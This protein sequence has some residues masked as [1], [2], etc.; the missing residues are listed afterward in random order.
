MNSEYKSLSDSFYGDN[1]RWFIGTVVNNQDP[2]Q[3]GRVQVRIV[4]IHSNSVTQIPQ[5]ALPWAQVMMPGTEGGIS[6]IGQSI[7]GL[8]PGAQVFGI[9]IDGNQSQIPFIFGSIPKE[10]YPSVIQRGPN[11]I[12]GSNSDVYENNDTSGGTTDQSSVSSGRGSV[13]LSGNSNAEKGFNFFVASGR[14]T[15][16]QAAGL[17]GNF[18]QESNMDPTA[19][20]SFSGEGSTGIAQWNPAARAGARLQALKRF[21]SSIGANYLSLDAQLQFVIHELDTTEI[22]GGRSLLAAN[23]VEQA[24]EAICWNY[25]RPSREHANLAGRIRYAQS[26]YKEFG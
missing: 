22:S 26:A 11:S 15:P 14:Y 2:M 3:A 24:T 16:E 8:Q 6:G 18:M 12:E 25:E 4:G 21:S 5:F 1:A 10:E 20:S 9:F 23:T 17:I 19:V 7:P 13:N